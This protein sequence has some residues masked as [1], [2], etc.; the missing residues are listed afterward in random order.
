VTKALA[1]GSVLDSSPVAALIAANID[2]AKVAGSG[3]E[4]R[5]SLVDRESGEL[6]RP[7]SPF[8]G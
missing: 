2:P 8:C 4:L 6:V 5:V 7:F 1:A 3:I